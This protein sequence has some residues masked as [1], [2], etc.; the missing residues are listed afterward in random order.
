M[1]VVSR[2]RVRSESFALGL[3]DDANMEGRMR[4]GRLLADAVAE[5]GESGVEAFLP[6]LAHF[7]SCL[8]GEEEEVITT[9]RRMGESRLM[10]RDAA[11][12]LDPILEGEVVGEPLWRKSDDATGAASR[13]I[14]FEG[15]ERMLLP[16]A[17]RGDFEGDAGGGG[18]LIE[19]NM[20]ASAAFSGDIGFALL[21]CLRS[22]D[23]RIELTTALGS[24]DNSIV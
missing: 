9:G 19:S 5:A 14:C 13:A 2:L 1:P 21:G 4:G 3:L 15:E 10:C 20:A 23:C 24:S 6:S 22:G 7:P 16:D 17:L 12:S 8:P 18:I 11:E